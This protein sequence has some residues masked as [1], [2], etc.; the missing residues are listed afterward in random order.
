VRT[1]L[2]PWFPAA[3]ALTFAVC[4]TVALLISSSDS[5]GSE[6]R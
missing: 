5:G 1:P 3:A 6:R 4:A 2:V